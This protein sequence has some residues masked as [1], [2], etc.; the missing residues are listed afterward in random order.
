MTIIPFPRRR[1]AAARA[2][3]VLS[4]P[5]PPPQPNIPPPGPPTPPAKEPPSEVPPE[6]PPVELPPV[7]PTPAPQRLPPSA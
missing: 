5:L 2:P 1:S 6:Q 4:D 3:L 7:D